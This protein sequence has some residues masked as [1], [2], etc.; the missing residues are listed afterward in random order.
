M[1]LRLTTLVERDGR[2]S[3]CVSMLWASRDSSLSPSLVPSLPVCV[4]R[5]PF[6][7]FQL[8]RINKTPNYTTRMD[9]VTAQ[10]TVT[11]ARDQEIVRFSSYHRYASTPR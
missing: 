5:L 7:P 6:G 1:S 9:E 10:K 2:G 8:E 11:A 3:R 4:C